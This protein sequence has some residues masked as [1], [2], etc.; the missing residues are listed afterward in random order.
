MMQR[1]LEIDPLSPLNNANLASFYIGAGRYNEAILQAKTALVID[2]NF[3]DAQDVLGTAYELDLQF[4]NAAAAFGKLADTYGENFVRL[5]MAHLYA[6]EGRSKEALES[7]YQ[8]RS[9]KIDFVS[10]PYEFA[11]IYARLGVKDQAFAMLEQAYNDHAEDLLE[12]KTE[13]DF[14]EYHSDPRFLNLL[15]RMSLPL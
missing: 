10:L 4:E 6:S 2:P 1:S 14:R 15:R 5:R 12:L 11:R 8:L 3:A 9:A 13:P 7:V